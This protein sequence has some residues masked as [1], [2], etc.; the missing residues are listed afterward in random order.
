VQVTEEV[1]YRLQLARG[2]L[3]EARQDR[4]LQRWRSCVDNSQL[5]VENAAKAALA[6]LG[7][8]GRTHNPAV[9][10]RA[11][12]REQRF[13]SSSQQV[14]QIAECAEFLGPDVHA[15][16]DYGD[17]AGWRTP[18]E[19]FDGTDAQ[20]ALSWAEKALSLVEQVVQRHDAQSFVHVF[21]PA[22]VAELTEV[23]AVLKGA[24]IPFSVAGSFSS[25]ADTEVWVE[26]PPEEAERARELLK[27]W[28]G[29]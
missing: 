29:H 24:G 5:A 18:W 26:V 7:P 16:S 2:F 21:H 13:P 4:D 28:S 3:A 19:L 20:Q 27:D 10:L 23:K 6:L 11:A 14:E 15:R 22:D 8:V 25:S 17:E 1:R 9:L 12:L